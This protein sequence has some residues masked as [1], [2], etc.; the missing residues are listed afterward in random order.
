MKLKKISEILSRLIDFTLVNT[1]EINDFS[2]GST[3]RSIYEAVA[4][5]L[6]Q[7]YILSRENIL[8]GIEQGVLN[9]FNFHKRNAKRAF[10]Q[11]TLE[12]HNTTQ[13]PIYVPTGSSFESSRKTNTGNA[14]TY[15]TEKDYII[16]Q[17]V[18]SAKIDVYCTVAGTQGNALAGEINKSTTGLSNLKSVTNE[19]DILTGTEEESIEAV[20][21]RFH[22][23]VE[24]RGRATIK[25]LDY[26]TRQVEDVS[27]V[28]IREEIGYVRIYAHD[29]NG[30][31]KEETLNKI[32]T[33]IEDYRP[34]GI[35]LDVLPVEK[36][37]VPI[38]IIVTITHK[39][40]ITDR[41]ATR[42]ETVIRSYLNSQTVS[43][44]LVLNDLKQAIM[45]IDD[46][47]IYDL[48]I[49]NLEENVTL[50]DEEIIRAGEVNV[51]LV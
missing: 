24:S 14:I 39:S 22:G 18:I 37:V 34:A 51:E 16:P 33:A 30:D 36:V 29:R 10:G 45:N 31:L 48:E 47:L 20:K 19:L 41:L 7:Y 28:Y 35:K 26:G 8:W 3:I 1:N 11:L 42:V 13:E 38:D 23:F 46:E 25:A 4:V 40:Q 2:V 49:T 32:K 44:T 27:G 15:V 6:E 50:R 5:E 17:G 43:Q 12:F 21:K 9:A